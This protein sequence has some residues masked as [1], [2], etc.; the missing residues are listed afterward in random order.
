VDGGIRFQLVDKFF[1][2]AG[3]SLW[4]SNISWWVAKVQTNHTIPLPPGGGRTP[5]SEKKTQVV[6]SC[7]RGGNPRR[8]WP[9]WSQAPECVSHLRQSRRE[10]PGPN[11]AARHQPSL[12]ISP[13]V[14]KWAIRAHAPVTAGS[15][16][17]KLDF[18]WG[19][20]RG[21]VKRCAVMPEVPRGKKKT[22]ARR[23][24]RAPGPLARSG[25]S[26]DPTPKPSRCRS[27]VAASSSG[28]ALK[29]RPIGIRTGDG[30][31]PLGCTNLKWNDA[32]PRLGGQ[33]IN[34]FVGE[35]GSVRSWFAAAGVA[36]I[37]SPAPNACSLVGRAH[38]LGNFRAFAWA[39]RARNSRKHQ[40]T[41]TSGGLLGRHARRRRDQTLPCAPEVQKRCVA[42]AS[43]PHLLQAAQGREPTPRFR[44][45][46]ARAPRHT[47]SARG[48]FEF[49]SQLHGG[50]DY[51]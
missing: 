20:G 21:A 22:Q 42:P 45:T 32:N 7:V 3:P 17:Y 15:Y 31:R 39:G 5:S 51:S 11:L 47:T 2:R 38:P 49:S 23:T 6:T 10:R 14:R 43:A 46:S 40:A 33:G 37:V 16:S 25:Q 4:G 29:A 9:L 19:A 36:G 44:R 1:R 24:D 35:T 26:P 13:R 30:M 34:D 48:A 8:E 28:A 50:P 41:T 18:L 27:I 12:Q